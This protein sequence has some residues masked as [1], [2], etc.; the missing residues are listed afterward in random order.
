M[1][2]AASGDTIKIDISPYNYTIH[3]QD[4][5]SGTGPWNRCFCANSTDKTD[6]SKCHECDWVGTK[7]G[8]KIHKAINRHK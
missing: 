1:S 3:R 5:F 4:C 2:T 8:L 7:H 6:L